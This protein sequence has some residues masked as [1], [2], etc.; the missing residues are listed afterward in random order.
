MHCLVATSLSAKSLQGWQVE[1]TRSEYRPSSLRKQSVF[2]PRKDI[3]SWDSFVDKKKGMWAGCLYGSGVGPRCCK[4]AILWNVS[5]CFAWQ[6]PQGLE[7]LQPM[8]E[9]LPPYL[10]PMRICPAVRS[11][12]LCAF[13][14]LPQYWPQGR[15]ILFYF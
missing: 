12:L 13:L 4:H 8:S 6:I 15:L 1:R 10:G 9:S 14:F 2:S 3:V 5:A 11:P 7:E